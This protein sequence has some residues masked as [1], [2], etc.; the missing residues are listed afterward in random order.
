MPLLE[1]KQLFDVRHVS[2]VYESAIIFNCKT[3]VMVV[4]IFLSYDKFVLPHSK[5]NPLYKT[6]G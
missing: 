5:N 2:D 6:P 4:F 3:C 1:Y